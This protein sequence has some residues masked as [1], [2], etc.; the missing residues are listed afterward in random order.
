MPDLRRLRRQ[1]RQG[2]PRVLAG[3][4]A[5]Q[6]F[7]SPSGPVT[8]DQGLRARRSAAEQPA[9]RTRLHCPLAHHQHEHC[10]SIVDSC[11]HACS[12]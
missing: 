4:P 12:L 2:V 6:G 10:V 3:Q 9:V 5:G 1:L 8:R 7:G 11:S